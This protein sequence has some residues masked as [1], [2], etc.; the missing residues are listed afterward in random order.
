[1]Q[2]LSPLPRK[3]TSRDKTLS[4]ATGL[5][6]NATL[7]A[8]NVED[9]G[10][11]EMR[12]TILGC[13][14][15]HV[16]DALEA[17]VSGPQTSVLA[18]W[19]HQHERAAHWAKKLGIRAIA[20]PRVD[21]ADAVIVMSETPLHRQLAELA[22]NARKPLFVEKPLATSYKEAQLIAEIVVRSGAVFHSGYF[23]RENEAFQQLRALIR[24]GGL[25]RIVR[26]RAFFAHGG[27]PAGWFDDHPWML[28]R[29][30]VGYG[31]F[32]DLGIHLVDLL[33]WLLDSPVSAVSACLRTMTPGLDLDDS[34]EA[35]LRLQDGTIATIGAGLAERGAPFELMITG[36]DGHASV[37]DGLLTVVTGSRT[38]TQT[39]EAPSATKGVQRF[40]GAAGGGS[41]ETLVTVGDAARHCAVLDAC[42]RAASCASW[43]EVRH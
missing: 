40:L 9:G 5:V 31:G 11:E 4:L 26:A 2:D 30:K 41:A 19:D 42:Y 34:G 28:K 18:V 36:T 8:E 23:L 13:A 43:V 38:L 7:V 14:H 17:I 39:V 20:K 3:E 37:R 22:A 32:G 6:F 1:M 25:G 33:T 21:D 16:K 24:R 15:I 10:E 29:E 12:V 27:V 35:L